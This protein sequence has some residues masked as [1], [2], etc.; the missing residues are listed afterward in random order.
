M[1]VEPR[2]GTAVEALLSPSR[3]WFPPVLAGALVSAT[4]LL[5]AKG[6]D[7]AAHTYQVIMFHRQG[8]MLWDKQYGGHWTLGYSVLYSPVAG[9]LGAQVTA[10]VSA[11]AAT[12]AFDRLASTHFGRSAGPGSI[13][14]A[15]SV[16]GQVAIG[17]LPFVLG[18]ALALTALVLASR[19]HRGAGF[20]LAVTASLAS[21]LAGAFAALGAAV[22]LVA[23]W[24]HDRLSPLAV[25]AG[26]GIPPLVIGGLFPGE[27]PM[28]FPFTHLA[29]VAALC[30]GLLLVLPREEKVL[31]AGVVVYLSAIVISFLIPTA[32]GGNIGRLGETVGAPIAM[33]L[34]SHRRRWLVAMLALPIFVM[35][36]PP[37]WAGLTA[38]R[39]DPSAQQT[40][41]T[42]LLA[43]LAAHPDG[44]ARLEIVPTKLHW[45]AAYVAP[46]AELA[47]SWERQLDTGNNT[48]FYDDEPL[49]AG[50]YRQWLL[51]NGVRYVALADAPLDYAAL[52]EGGLVS[53]GASGLQPVWHDA[54]WR[55]FVVAGS[56]GIVSGPARLTRLAGSVIGLD[57]ARPGSITVRVHYSP[58]WSASGG[59]ACIAEGPA[60]T[61]IVQARHPGP[62]TLV[63]GVLPA[64]HEAC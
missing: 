55:V 17:Q 63:L 43:F 52:E 48:V 26:A 29:M 58:N 14:F 9:L 22:W 60:K 54:H 7:L 21:P 32:L 25:C 37:A 61:I 39:V 46:H 57:V 36:L 12:W 47:R 27:G 11:I 24:R 5:G 18:E 56:P 40:Y 31:R 64:P 15:L 6:I 1:H 8:L 45:E 3:S 62:M 49:S 42:P 50:V 34:M 28:P 44:G 2:A 13:V 23:W 30:L 41:F 20:V 10:L 53:H 33:C 35:P 59:D 38:N 19:R 4:I 51:D 16:A